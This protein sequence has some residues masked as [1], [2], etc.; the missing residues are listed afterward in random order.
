MREAL[1]ML[2]GA[3]I[4]LVAMMLSGAWSRFLREDDKNKTARKGNDIHGPVGHMAGA[5][6][7]EKKDAGDPGDEH[8]GGASGA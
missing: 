4:A 2:A 5:I 1:L 8:G 7:A 3:A 6:H